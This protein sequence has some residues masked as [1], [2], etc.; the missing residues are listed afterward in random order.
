[1]KKIFLLS[2]MAL[3]AFSACTK[4]ERFENEVQ[5]GFTIKANI[6]DV[7]DESK[8]SISNVGKNTWSDG[9]SIAVF[10]GGKAYKFVLADGAGSGL[11]IDE[12]CLCYA[13]QVHID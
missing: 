11:Y 5:A 4:E 8:I 1:M 6:A 3:V 12:I 9:D 2:V 13:G 10:F 7:M